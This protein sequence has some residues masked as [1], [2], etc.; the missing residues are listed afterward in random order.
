MTCNVC[1]KAQGSYSMLKSLIDL[2]FQSAAH[3]LTSTLRFE[4]ICI[5]WVLE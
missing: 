2:I 5:P 4:T 1:V 3:N